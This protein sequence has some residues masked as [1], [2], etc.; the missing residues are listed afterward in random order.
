MHYIAVQ[1]DDQVTFRIPQELAR[2]LARRARERRVPKSQLVREAV[3]GYLE[4][5]TPAATDLRAAIERFRA[6][7][8]LDRGAIERDTVT[9]QIR[10]HN[11]R[12]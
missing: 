5:S 7:A 6:I 2:A 8:P 12:K 10:E 1:M 4:A 3:R 9:R 11:W